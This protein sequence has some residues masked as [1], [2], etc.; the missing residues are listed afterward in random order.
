MI[1]LQY[2]LLCASSGYWCHFFRS[3]RTLYRISPSATCLFSS[4]S[5]P[6]YLSGYTDPTGGQA[7]TGLALRVTWPPELRQRGKVGEGGGGTG[8]KYWTGVQN[9]LDDSRALKIS[10]DKTP[11]TVYELKSHNKDIQAT[12]HVW[13]QQNYIII[14][15]ARCFVWVWNLVS[16]IE[17]E[18]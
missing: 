5:Y 8:R 14:I 10:K 17:G 6:L 18:K 1:D 7:T 15:I 11:Y 2:H 4:G 9:E 16:N 3:Q 12:R 13:N